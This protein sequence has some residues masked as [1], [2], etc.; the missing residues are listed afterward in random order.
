MET[1]L[2]YGVDNT[3]EGQFR[4]EAA[5]TDGTAAVLM[6]W[7][8]PLQWLPQVAKVDLFTDDDTH[9]PADRN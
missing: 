2:L 6:K 4:T 3:P 7:T 5:F 9:R 8:E 1:P